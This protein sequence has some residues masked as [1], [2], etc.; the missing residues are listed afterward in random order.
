MER[1][2]QSVVAPAA[3]PDRIAS[4]DVVEGGG[5]HGLQHVLTE[6]PGG[7]SGGQRAATTGKRRRAT[8]RSCRPAP[9][10]TTLVG[11]TELACHRR[12]REGVS[13]CGRSA[14]DEESSVPAIGVSRGDGDPGVGA[15]HADPTPSAEFGGILRMSVGEGRRDAGFVGRFIH[16]VDGKCEERAGVLRTVSETGSICAMEWKGVGTIKRSHVD[17]RC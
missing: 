1:H 17:G 5:P 13:L 9:A 2:L 3:D 11:S 16:F 14:G 6:P 4:A 12:H 8:R 15:M 7:R 10:V